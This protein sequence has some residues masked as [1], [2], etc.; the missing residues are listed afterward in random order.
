M[1]LKRYFIEGLAHASYLVGADGEAAIVDPK[2]DVDDYLA[3]AERAGLKIT[4]ILNSHPP[5]ISPAALRNWPRAP[6]Q[7]FTPRIARQ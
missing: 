1:Y 3:D 6:A 7:S 4:A 2:R 5:R